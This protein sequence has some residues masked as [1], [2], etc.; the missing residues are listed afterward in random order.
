[1]SQDAAIN[2]IGIGYYATVLKRR[3]AV[4]ALCTLL[5]VLAGVAVLE[6]LPTRVTATTT[7]N[8]NVISTDPFNPGRSASGLVDL[9]TEA[10]VAGS[11]VVAQEASK[12]LG[13]GQ[14]A[15]ELRAGTKITTTAEATVLLVSYTADSPQ[16]AREGA[17]AVAAAY[18]S[19]R[20]ETASQRLETMLDGI[21]DRLEELRPQL[22]E[23]NTRFATAAPGSSE[24]V[25]ADSDRQLIT[26]E[27][28]K[29]MLRSAE[30]E[31]VDTT[32]GTV[33]S[34]STGSDVEYEPNPV[35]LVSSGVASG[36]V[37]GLVLAFVAGALDRRVRDGG[38][39]VAATHAPVLAELAAHDGEPEGAM[40]S[41]REARERVMAQVGSP[42]VLVTLD[43]SA[44]A[45]H[46]EVPAGLATAMAQDGYDIEL[47]LGAPGQE[48]AAELRVAAN[49]FRPELR[50]GGGLVVPGRVVVSSAGS[51][52]EGAAD[53]DV[54]AALRHRVAHAAATKRFVIALLPDA[55]TSTMLAIGRIADAVVLVVERDRTTASDLARIVAEMNDVKAPVVGSVVVRRRGSRRRSGTEDGASGTEGPASTP[56]AVSATEGARESGKARSPKILDR[57]R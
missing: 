8:M 36:L 20:G 13:A 5:G 41:F 18:L 3:W 38:A 6:I 23:A 49:T 9:S 54:A 43:A 26:A 19:Y 37:I 48:A 32:G 44:G 4:I 33:L 24:S 42:R 21:T 27:I 25:Q 46:L 47:V 53:G 55:P 57:S 39:V 14:S 7:V 12:L 17:D 52:E 35:L 31:Q 30:L 15:E 16:S 11:F 1:M 22:L 29:L 28:D 40:A 50:G 56:G 10:A 34:P 51:N 2:S 45:G